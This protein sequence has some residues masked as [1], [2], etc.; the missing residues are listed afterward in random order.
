[1]RIRRRFLDRRQIKSSE[2]E[3]LWELENSY[4]LSPK[5]SSSIMTTAKECLL[6]DYSLRE[7]QIEVT[8]IGI[9]ERSGKV[10]EKMEKKKVRLTIDNGIEDIEILKE[11]GRISLRQIKIERITD[12]AIEQGGV[13]SQE[14]LSKY[15]GCTV[16]TIQRDIKAIKKKGIEVVTR[17]YLH[18][19]G[20][21]QT[22]KVKII[23]MY[24]DGKTYSEIKLTARHSA[25]AIKRYLESFT[26]VL[27][28]QSKGI[29]ERK[30]ISSVTGISEGLVKQ[31]LELIKESKK[32]KIKSENLKDLISRNSYRSGIKKTAKLYSEPL[33]AMMRGL[34]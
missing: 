34:L 32:D 27:M 33:G 28:A 31:Y 13:L 18:N 17:G 6:R 2:G 23:G 24:L 25:G 14:D 1:M 10:I 16:R 26:K 5:L 9:E 8:V 7:G 4:S 11:Y 3:L 15:L 12:E 20:R 22:H 19:I 21:G 30:E 29:Y